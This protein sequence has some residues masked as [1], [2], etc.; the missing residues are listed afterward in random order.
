MIV[1]FSDLAFI[2][3]KIALPAAKIANE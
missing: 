3:A 2:L 1:S